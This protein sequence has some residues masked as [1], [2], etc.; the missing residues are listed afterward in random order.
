MPL[1]YS[2][3]S[4]SCLPDFKNSYLASFGSS[5]CP[6]DKINQYNKVATYIISSLAVAHR[7]VLVASIFMLGHFGYMSVFLLNFNFMFLFVFVAVAVRTI[8]SHS[9]SYI[10]FKFK[11]NFIIY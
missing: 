7:L 3:S 4:K 8:S 11:S 10:Y 1:V 9:L 6:K 5:G 2:N